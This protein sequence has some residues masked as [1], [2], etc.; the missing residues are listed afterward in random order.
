MASVLY[1]VGM[2]RL[3]PLESD[4]WFSLKGRGLVF[5]FTGDKVPDNMHHPREYLNKRVTIDGH[6]YIV[7]G[8]ETFPIN[9][10]QPYRKSFGLLVRPV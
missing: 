2:T 5:T 9:D 8:V 4:G 7:K 6:D 1:N 10:H 3:R